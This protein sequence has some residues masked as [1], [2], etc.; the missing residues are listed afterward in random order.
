MTA[1]RRP[2]PEHIAARKA[3]IAKR[4]AWHEKATKRPRTIAAIRVSELTRLF[5]YRYSR[6]YLPE[7]DDT[8]IAARIMA[9]H[10]GSLRD[11]PRRIEAWLAT[12]TPWLGLAERERLISEVAECPLRWRADKLGWKLRLSDVERRKLKITTIGAFDVTKAERAK[13]RASSKRERERNRRSRS[14][15]KSR[16]AYL[17]QQKTKAPPW[18]AA[19]LT[20]STW[21]RRQRTTAT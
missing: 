14:G 19:G 18:T 16:A 1:P 20:R 9:H 13:R 5:D 11:A 12:C 4:Y 3:E 6:M 15:A 2:S 17:A 21:Y 8:L 10:L 7:G